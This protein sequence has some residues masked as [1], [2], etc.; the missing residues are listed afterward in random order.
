M[1]VMLV[2][3]AVVSANIRRLGLPGFAPFIPV[4]GYAFGYGAAFSI[5]KYRAAKQKRYIAVAV[6]CLTLLALNIL[7]YIFNPAI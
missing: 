6:L 4:L 1:L 5:G 3:F 7:L 2:L